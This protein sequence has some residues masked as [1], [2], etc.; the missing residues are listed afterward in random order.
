M[1]A[2]GNERLEQLQ[3]NDIN[4]Y[5]RFLPS[6]SLQTLAPGFTRTYFRGVASGENGNHSGPLPSVGTYLDEQPITTITGALDI[7]VYDIAR[8]EALAGPQGTLYGASS[9]A[10]TVRIITNKP[11][12]GEFSAS[13]NIGINSIDGGG[14]GNS[15]EGYVNIPLGNRAAVRLVGWSQHDAGYIDNVQ[16]T[17]TYPTCA[18][19]LA[20]IPPTAV[21]PCTLDNA[22]IAED[23]YNDV[24]TYGFRAALGIELNDNWTVTPTLMAQDQQSNG[25]FGF[26]PAVGDL[27]LTHWFPES[28]Q[29]SWV[30]AA[31]TV[32]GVIGRFRLCLF[33]RRPQPRH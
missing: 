18:A 12:P 27:K 26:D 13:Y 4:D 21:A 14:I 33:G 6:L 19:G 17:R 22:A 9:Q 23:D 29:D 15:I 3:V 28:A 20:A 8:V 1:Q 25:I 7:H 10:G 11:D 2:I 32:N 16:G 5:A 31:L 24:D 30:Q